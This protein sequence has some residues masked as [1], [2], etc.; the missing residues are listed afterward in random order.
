MSPT[1]E[2]R[3]R[4]RREVIQ[5]LRWLAVATVMLYLAVVAIGGAVWHQSRVSRDETRT[6]HDALCTYRKNL[7]DAAASSR[8]FLKEHPNGIPGISAAQIRQSIGRQEATVA[9]L[10]ILKCADGR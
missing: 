1:E 8:A 7:K 9:S 2:A 4:A 3:I 10:A 6:T 5:W